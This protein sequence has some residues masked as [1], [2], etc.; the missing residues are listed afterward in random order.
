MMTL[1]MMVVMAITLMYYKDDEDIDSRTFIKI[2]MANISSDRKAVS[3]SLYC[4]IVRKLT[5]EV[6]KLYNHHEHTSFMH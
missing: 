2:K 5:F 3:L 4:V 6:F 1:T